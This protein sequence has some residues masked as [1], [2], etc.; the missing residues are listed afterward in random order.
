MGFPS[1]MIIS[2]MRFFVNENEGKRFL[3]KDGNRAYCSDEG[4]AS[5]VKCFL[6]SYPFSPPACRPETKNFWQQMNTISTGTRL[7]MDM[8]KT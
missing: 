1:I 7:A 2:F 3:R 8:A 6:S 4:E 5:S